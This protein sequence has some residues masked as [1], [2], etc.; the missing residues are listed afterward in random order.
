M[1]K[2]T[3]AKKKMSLDGQITVN[4]TSTW[5]AKRDPQRS[6]FWWARIAQHSNPLKQQ[7]P[8]R[9]LFLWARRGSNPRPHPSMGVMRC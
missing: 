3:S 7:D 9:I 4:G 2:K 5:Y 6:R 1:R 8:R